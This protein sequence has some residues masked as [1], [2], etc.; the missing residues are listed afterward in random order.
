MLSDPKD[1]V[2]GGTFFPSLGRTLKLRKGQ[3]LIHPGSLFHKGV[4]IRAGVRNLMVCFLDAAVAG[5]STGIVDSLS[6][7]DT[8]LESIVVAL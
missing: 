8:T 2:G 4:S 7:E 3:V 1:Y 5:Y 6:P